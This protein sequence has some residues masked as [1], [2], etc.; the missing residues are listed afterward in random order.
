MILVDNSVV[1]DDIRGK[2]ANLQALIARHPV[3][4]CGFV[5]AEILCGARNAAHR[6]KLLANLAAYRQ[7]PFPELLWDVVGDNLAALRR[8]GFTFPFPDVAVATLGIHE[9]IE[10][11]TRDRHF[12]DIQTVL[13]ALKLFQEPP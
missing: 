12:A 4:I 11:W 3:T 1:I 13:P 6:S 8:S 2:D 7:L 5:S 9:D 10:V